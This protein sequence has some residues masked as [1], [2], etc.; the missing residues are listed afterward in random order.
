M[1]IRISLRDGSARGGRRT[2]RAPRIVDSL[3][4]VAEFAGVTVQSVSAW[5]ERGAPVTEDGRYDLWEIARWHARNLTPRPYPDTSELGNEDASTTDDDADADLA[6]SDRAD[7]S[8]R[9]VRAAALTAELRLSEAEGRVI[10]RT[11][12]DAAV[13][14]LVDTFVSALEVM[15]HRVTPMLLAAR[16]HQEI[17]QVLSDHIRAMRIQLVAKLSE[18]AAG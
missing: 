9:R 5:F 10:T 13:Y 18:G 7:W 11:A 6:D 4:A 12:H 3:A 14:E 17:D 16:G 2:P 8:I 15:P 1:P